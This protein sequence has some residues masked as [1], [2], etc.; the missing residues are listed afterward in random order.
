MVVGSYGKNAQGTSV[1]FLYKGGKYT[2]I[3]GP[4]GAINSAA[5]GINDSGA[6]V[7]DYTDATGVTHGFLLKKGK[8]TTLDAPGAVGLTV[9]SGINSAGAIVLWYFKDSSGDSG[10]AMT[11]NNGKTY[12]KLAVPGAGP[13]GD[14]AEDIN[15]ANDVCFVYFD[16]AARYHAALL[17]GGKYYKFNP[18][19]SAES[20]A[21]GLNDKMTVA[22]IWSVKT[23]GVLQGYKG[24]YH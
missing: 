6:I 16:T 3:L 8:Y 21:S 1:G 9:A 15:G 24:V 4:K 14:A 11:T 10:S 12:K 13:A 18:F 22:G 2:D 7:G 19:K 20:T 5:Y 23:N 17:H